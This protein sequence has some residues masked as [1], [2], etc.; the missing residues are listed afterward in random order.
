MTADT[1]TSTTD[2]I[3]EAAPA[4]AAH[5]GGGWLRVAPAM[6]LLA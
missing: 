3:T 5:A 1:E 2:T 4:D 6:F